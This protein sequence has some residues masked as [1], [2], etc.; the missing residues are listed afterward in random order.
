MKMKLLIVVL[1]LFVILAIG[2]LIVLPP[3][4]GKIPQFKDSSGNILTNSIAEKTY[5]DID[6]AKIGLILLGEDINNP[7][8]LVCG[9]GP[10]IPEY[11]LEG[12]YSS[13]L[14]KHF[15]VCYF[16]YRGTGLSFDKNVSPAE[17]TTERYL[18]DVDAITGYLQGRFQ[19]EKVYIMGHSFGT[20]I[21]IHAVERHPENYTAYLA[22]S[23]IC[24][25]RESEYRAYDYMLE[26][27]S[28]M[29]NKKM[30]SKFESYPIRENEEVYQQYCTSGLRDKAMH[31]LGV[32]TARDMNSVI[33]GLFFPSLRCKSYTLG[34]RINI[35]RGKINSNQFAV[36]NEGFDFNAFE[37]ID[38]I[39]IPIYFFA[40]QYDYTCCYSLQK[41]YYDYVDAPEKHYYLYPDAAH[42]PI[43]EDPEMTEKILNDLQ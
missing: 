3:G 13:V 6:G 29:K 11:L 2:L 35:W 5:I 8:L 34:E 4:R 37:E 14:P 38:S 17:M 9:G 32:G 33:S 23:Q 7:V 30:V 21:A 36:T 40:G 10:G 25:Q 28:S 22:V 26:Q 1:V 24:N 16:D 18:A 39:P 27:Y 41:E 12:M 43:F 19:S 42:S 15:V 20:Y 31:E